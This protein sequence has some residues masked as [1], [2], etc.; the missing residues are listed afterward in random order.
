MELL[1]QLLLQPGLLIFFHQLVV[2]VQRSKIGEANITFG[3]V[4]HKAQIN[5]AEREFV[6]MSLSQTISLH[7][8]KCITEHESKAKHRKGGR[9][10][11]ISCRLRETITLLVVTEGRSWEGRVGD[12]S[13]VPEI[14]GGGGAALLYFVENECHSVSFRCQ[15]SC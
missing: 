1:Y 8:L 11:E 9:V 12:I 3:A 7:C 4:K 5:F 13:W 14:G 10:W 6:E 15:A 2:D